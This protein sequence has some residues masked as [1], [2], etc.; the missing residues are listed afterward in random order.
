[1]IVDIPAEKYLTELQLN[2]SIAKKISDPIEEDDSSMITITKYMLDH[3]ITDIRY[4]G[5]YIWNNE[6]DENPISHFVVV[7]KK[8]KRIMFL[9]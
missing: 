2:P 4:R 3:G 6:L 1:M 7:G 8:G 5:M 9:T